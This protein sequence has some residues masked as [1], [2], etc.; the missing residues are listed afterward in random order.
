MVP[1][2]VLL[3]SFVLFALVGAAGVH[4]FAPWPAALRWALVV[5]FLLTASA[6]FT[7]TRVDLVR[8]VPR[9]FPNPGLLVTLTGFLELAGALG[10]V[11]PAT[12]TLAALGLVAL[13]VAMFP[14]NAHAARAGLTL[15]GKPIMPVVP[16][17]AIQ[18][19]FIVAIALAGFVP[20]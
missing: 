13:L 2:T 4:F 17:L 15:R 5:M 12:R 20:G 16:R 18:I 10:L 1:L 3:A 14:A 19:V 7:K 6:H 11:V 9:A 8:M